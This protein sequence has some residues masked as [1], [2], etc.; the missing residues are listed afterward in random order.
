MALNTVR[1]H[2]VCSLKNSKSIARATE[3]RDLIASCFHQLNLQL[4]HQRCIC[5]M[6]IHAM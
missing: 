6:L 3:S 1:N 2:H 5:D 4:F